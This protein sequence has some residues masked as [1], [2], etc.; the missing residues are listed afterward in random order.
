[1]NYIISMAIDLNIENYNFKDLLH[2]FNIPYDFSEKDLKQAKKIVLKTHPDKSGLDQKFFFFYSAAYK[3][4]YRTHEFRVKRT[5]SVNYS[6]EQTEDDL[7][8]ERLLEKFQKQNDKNFNKRFNEMFEKVKIQSDDDEGYGEWLRSNEGIDN[9]KTT[10]NNMNTFFDQ[11]KSETRALIKKTD[12]ESVNEGANHSYLLSDKPNYYTSDV[13][14]NLKYEDLKRAHIESVVPVTQEDYNIK[15]KFV[16]T[17]EMANHRSR[18]NMTPCG[19]NQAKQFLRKKEQQ[20]NDENITI[21]YKFAKQDEDIKKANDLWWG[22][23]RQ[24]SN[25]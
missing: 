1:M 6:I 20:M 19:L 7:E 23:L 3:L 4:L 15:K 18:Q 22:N 2:L 13:F 16:D 12:I 24:L 21:A 5:H 25:G 17:N 11:K 14:S 9:R 8:K 10:K